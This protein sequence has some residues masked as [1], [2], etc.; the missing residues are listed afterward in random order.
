[1]NGIVGIA[2]VA[3]DLCRGH[4]PLLDVKI[5]RTLREA[6]LV[7]QHAALDVERLLI[8]VHADGRRVVLER[9]HVRAVDIHR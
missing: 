4:T 7:L 3:D 9:L 8:F 1:M 2:V 6:G 5:E